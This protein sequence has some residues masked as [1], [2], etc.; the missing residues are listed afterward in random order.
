MVDV[1]ASNHCG[2]DLGPLEVWFRVSGY[3]QGD[4]VQSVL[5]HPFDPLPRDGETEVHIVL[6]G[7]IDWYDRIEVQVT[8]PSS[9]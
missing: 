5:G 8:P 7:S 9:P 4:L 3:R 2:R 1:R 6:P